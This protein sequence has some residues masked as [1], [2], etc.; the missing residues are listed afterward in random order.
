MIAVY[1]GI[2]QARS[3][4][5]LSRI[6]NNFTVIAHAFVQSA[7]KKWNVSKLT[8]IQNSD[9]HQSKIQSPTL[10]KDLP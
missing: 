8:A 3:L 6:H 1:T 10:M 4:Y 5:T 9:G 2:V 7:D